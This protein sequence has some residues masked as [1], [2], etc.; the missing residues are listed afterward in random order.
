[1]KKLLAVLLSILCML[2][3]LCMPTLAAGEIQDALGG[4]LGS[5]SLLGGDEDIIG[6]GVVYKYETLSDVTVLYKPAPSVSFSNPGTYTITSDT[7]LSVDYQFVCWK[8]ADTGKLYYAGDK[9]YVD[10]QITFYAVW[11]EKTDN[12]VRVVRTIKTSIEAFRRIL[13][14]FFKVFDAAK[15]AFEPDEPV[16][17]PTY[18]TLTLTQDDLIIK[19]DLVKNYNVI[20][21]YIKSSYLFDSNLITG[22]YI[23]FKPA[24]Y[25]T[26]TMYP[27]ELSITNE[28]ETINGETY[29]Y[30]LATFLDGVPVP[31][32]ATEIKFTIP[33]NFLIASVGDTT[34]ASSE[35]NGS[36]LSTDS[37]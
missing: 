34:Y 29:Q 22:D 17:A 9:V 18:E 6:Y 21:I 8:H 3:S 35:I 28:T 16:T 5:D 32:R 27:V 11:E 33:E 1:M 25:I 2:T 19:Y 10:G 15:D 26:T 37:L 31:P 7:P 36:F 13:G 14:K 30:I 24:E 4:L 23:S 20:K 12:D